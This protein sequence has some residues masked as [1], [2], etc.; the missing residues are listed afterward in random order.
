MGKF[1]YGGMAQSVDI[2][3]RTL[4]HLRLAVMNKLRRSEPFM[5]DYEP[6]DGTGRRSF[7]MHPAVPMQFHFYSGRGP[8]INLAWVEELVIAAS[9]P[10]GL[11]IMP[12]PPEPRVSPEHP[13]A[14][15]SAAAGEAAPGD[16][17]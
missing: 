8:R 7:W 1:I 6:G 12:E 3:D 14:G 10:M 2:E 16:S 4:A 11:R 15:E 17:A 5:F 13:V 9:G